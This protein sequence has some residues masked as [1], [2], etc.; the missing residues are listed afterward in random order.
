MGRNLTLGAVL[1]FG[2]ATGLWVAGVSDDGGITEVREW[3]FDS[4]SDL[5]VLFIQGIGSTSCE[6]RDEPAAD[7]AEHVEWL[8][9]SLKSDVEGVDDD[10]FLYYTYTSGEIS[11]ARPPVCSA[12][13][14]PEAGCPKYD[15]HDAC[16]SLDDEYSLRGEGRGNVIG[17]AQRLATYID[18]HVKDDAKL[19]IVAHSQGGVLAAYTVKIHPGT[20]RAIVTLDSPLG[21]ISEDEADALRFLARACGGDRREDSHR[22]MESDTQ[23][24]QKAGFGEPP[25][26]TKL[27]TIDADPGCFVRIFSLCRHVSKSESSWQEAHLRAKADTH[28]D[29][30]QGVFEGS[31]E[32]TP[33][34]TRVQSFIACAVGA[35]P[36][37]C[38]EYADRRSVGERDGGSGR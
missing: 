1:L 22:D 37:N 9:D 3:V 2:G 11:A 20:V 10:S 34:K 31:A 18:K 23:V 26:N 35:F 29:I 19:T 12:E 21:G 16:W 36:E 6:N 28:S 14:C 7:F 33:A 24:I 27:Y 17:Q 32:Q 8:R 25:E 13:P 30:W 38:E 15:K 4:D 5:R